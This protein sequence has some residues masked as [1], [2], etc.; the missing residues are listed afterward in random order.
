MKFSVVTPTLNGMPQ[1]RKCVGSVRSQSGTNVLVEHIA[2]DGESTDGTDVFLSEYEIRPDV[3]NSETYTFSSHCEPDS[4]MYEAINRGWTKASG[5]ILSW[6]NHDE[7][8]LPDTLEKVLSVFLEKPDVDIVFGNMIIVDPSGK[9][10]AARREIPLH[11][12]YVKND[13][14]YAISCTTFFR[15]RLLDEGL[16]LF[17]TQYKAAGDMDLILKLLSAGKKVKHISDYLALFGVNGNNLT[18][19]LGATMADETKAIQ[20][21]YGG[22][23]YAVTR[24]FVKGIR[25][26][27]RAC[28]GC[29]RSADIAYDYAINEI[30]EYQHVSKDSV[31]FR[32]TY[33]RVNKMMAND[34]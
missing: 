31:G 9:P 19:S 23:P 5:E 1:I 27:E 17:D 4:G 11:S 14:L 21:K 2:Q 32:F 13:F 8:Y 20:L 25:F 33:D 29:Y 12:S 26:L 22:S 7:Q 16:L 15:R 18:V 10:L 3:V 6:L 28:F 34:G 30:P 24:K